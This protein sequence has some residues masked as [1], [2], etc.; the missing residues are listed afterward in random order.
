MCLRE[1]ETSALE[2]RRV[3]HGEKQ[4]RQFATKTFRIIRC[5]RIGSRTTEALGNCPC[6]TDS[7]GGRTAI[8]RFSSPNSRAIRRTKPDAKKKSPIPSGLK[9]KQRG[10]GRLF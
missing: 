7:K 4:R 2:D 5:L 3:S 1:M 8:V 9:R 10:T 6:T